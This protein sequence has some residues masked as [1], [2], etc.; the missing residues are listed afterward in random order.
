MLRNEN[1][2]NTKYR[3]SLDLFGE[4]LKSEGH[5]LLDSGV[6]DTAFLDCSDDTHKVVISQNHS[7]RALGN[8]REAYFFFIAE[9]SGHKPK[10]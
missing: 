2:A 1:H 6:D 8:L 9:R 3:T 5:K 7:R 4:L 10:L